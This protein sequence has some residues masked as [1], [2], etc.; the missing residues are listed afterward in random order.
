M[1]ISINNIKRNKMAKQAKK[2]VTKAI[3]GNT[4][5]KKGLSLSKRTALFGLVGI[6]A[7]STVAGIGWQK[8]QEHQLKAKAAS[9][10]WTVVSSYLLNGKRATLLA[11]KVSTSGAYGPVWELH[12]YMTNPTEQKLYGNLLVYRNHDYKNIVSNAS[13]VLN[14]NSVMSKT[15]ITYA[16]QILDDT[17]YA[18][19]AK[20]GM[21]AA[22][23]PPVHLFSEITNC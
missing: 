21:G 13:F 8:W 23:L 17:W 15:A 22:A 5:S 1:V 10:N 18:L 12:S 20:G 9:M 3:V 7:F 19:I 4:K 6:L 14:P 2:P 11:C 16:S